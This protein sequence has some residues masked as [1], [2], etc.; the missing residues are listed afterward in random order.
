MIID[1]Q[2]LLEDMREYEN[3]RSKAGKMYTQLPFKLVYDFIALV[4]QFPRCIEFASASE[5]D[6]DKLIKEEEK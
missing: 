4:E 5:I 1:T 3:E 2:V 6:L